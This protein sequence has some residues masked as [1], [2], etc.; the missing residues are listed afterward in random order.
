MN[1][2]LT[3]N[4]NAQFCNIFPDCV[5]AR[6]TSA[7]IYNFQWPFCM[8]WLALVPVVGRS[9]VHR[10]AKGGERKRGTPFIATQCTNGTHWTES[11]TWEIIV[12]TADECC[13][14]QITF[15]L[16][17]LRVPLPRSLSLSGPRRSWSLFREWTVEGAGRLRTDND[18]IVVAILSV[19]K[20][21]INRRKIFY[22]K[23]LFLL[24]SLVVLHTKCIGDTTHTVSSFVAGTSDCRV[25]A[26]KLTWPMSSLHATKVPVSFVCTH[27]SYP[28]Y[29]NWFTFN[30]NWACAQ[31]DYVE[32]TVALER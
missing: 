8:A 32:D 22:I 10:G 26:L 23:L 1:S 29:F 13:T 4:C 2:R 21:Q 17:L 19:H 25:P 27:S 11:V 3:L 6:T 5:P 15:L 9:L 18:N 16:L 20:K 24:L 12:L 30:Y 7:T 28:S 14:F 31:A